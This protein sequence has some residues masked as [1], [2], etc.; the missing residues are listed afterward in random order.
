MEKAR[1]DQAADYLLQKSGFPAA[2]F[3]AT[4]FSPSLARAPVAGTTGVV[5]KVSFVQ[6]TG[7]DSLKKKQ[8][9]CESFVVIYKYC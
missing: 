3:P 1:E 5:G 7:S 8:L 9:H 6:V 2:D 4:D